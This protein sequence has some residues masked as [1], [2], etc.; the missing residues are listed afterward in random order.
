MTAN[1]IDPF[2]V[3]ILLA[4][5]L[6]GLLIFSQDLNNLWP[7][8]A[9]VRHK[10]LKIEFVKEKKK[11]KPAPKKAEILSNIDKKVEVKKKP[12]EKPKPIVEP[13]LEKPKPIIKPIVPPVIKAKPPKPA[14]KLKAVAKIE[15]QKPEVVVKKQQPV[16]PKIE[17]VKPK[18]QIVKVSQP[19]KPKELKIDKKIVKV[20]E[21]EII[22]KE[23]PRNLQLSPSLTTLARWDQQQSQ[24]WVQERLKKIREA[25]FDLSSKKVKHAA[26]FGVVKR[27]IKRK[28]IYPAEAQKN[29]IEGNLKI[30][31]TIGQYGKL[32]DI[33][34]KKSSGNEMLDQAAVNAIHNAA[35]FAPLPREWQIE[36]LNLNIEFNYDLIR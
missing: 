6:H 8:T 3:A 7:K 13:K 36:R 2:P 4:L 20:P 28:W 12:V 24:N 34:I 33:T 27:G 15:K 25:T 30:L 26:Y 21:K 1:R 18:Q 9:K 5:L 35:P 29:L 31:F 19:A 32:L 10:P 16:K 11:P 22:I 23:I 14:N 17:P